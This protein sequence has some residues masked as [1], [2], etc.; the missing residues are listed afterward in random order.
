MHGQTG[1]VG[2]NVPHSD[3]SVQCRHSSKHSRRW[4]MAE[5][6]KVKQENEN[7]RTGIINTINHFLLT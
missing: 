7:L 1:Q 5:L 6:D 2:D 4:L 3:S